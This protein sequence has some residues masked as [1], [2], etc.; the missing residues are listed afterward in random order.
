MKH[1]SPPSKKQL[2]SSSLDVKINEILISGRQK[3]NKNLD[4]SY[5][6]RVDLSNNFAK[7]YV[8]NIVEHLFKLFFVSCFLEGGGVLQFSFVFLFVFL[9]SN[10]FFLFAFSRLRFSFYEFLP[11][12][13]IT[14]FG[15]VD[16]FFRTFKSKKRKKR[17]KIFPYSK[18]LL[19]R[20]GWPRDDYHYTCIY[21]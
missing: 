12:F 6:A 19:K 17:K 18:T 7:L 13:C 2:Q 9:F 21:I 10:L 3:Q 14:N 15:N 20:K 11:F 8:K 5:R 16:F 1:A 4:K